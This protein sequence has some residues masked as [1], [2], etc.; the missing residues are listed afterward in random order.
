[1]RVII[2]LVLAL[3]L[4]VVLWA[5]VRFSIVSPLRVRGASARL[6]KPDAKGVERICGFCPPD[7]LVQFYLRSPLVTR[8]EVSLLDRSSATPKEWFVGSFFPL[9]AID[10][11]ENLRVFGVSGVIPIADDQAKG[12]YL[13]ESS[14]SVVFR[15]SGRSA[16]LVAVAKDVGTF[17]AFEPNECPIAEDS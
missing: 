4:L 13:V 10:A 16:K 6:R 12:V 17:A 5:I 9:T 3:P 8:E 7:D 11:A 15:P 1:M 14:G 2:L